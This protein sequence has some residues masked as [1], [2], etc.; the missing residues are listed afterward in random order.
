[1]AGQSYLDLG[2]QFVADEALPVVIDDPIIVPC[3][4]TLPQ[5]ASIL[6]DPAPFPLLDVSK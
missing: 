5:P 6:M 2:E 3:T 1:M 4:A